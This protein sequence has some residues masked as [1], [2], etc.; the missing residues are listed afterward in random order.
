MIRKKSRGLN[1]TKE[2]FAKKLI[3]AEL[4]VNYDRS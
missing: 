2:W 1:T 4:K 3:N